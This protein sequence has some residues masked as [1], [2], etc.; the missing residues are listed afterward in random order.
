MFIGNYPMEVQ[1]NFRFSKNF[2]PVTRPARNALLHNRIDSLSIPTKAKSDIDLIEIGLL[3]AS[4]VNAEIDK[5]TQ[6]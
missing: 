3:T 5:T 4:T 1:H 6:G 2:T